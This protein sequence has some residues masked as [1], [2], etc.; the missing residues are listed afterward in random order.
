MP[1]NASK[2]PVFGRNV[3]IS[4]EN[5]LFFSMSILT[6]KPNRLL[7]EPVYSIFL[8]DYSLLVASRSPE[9]EKIAALRAEKRVLRLC[10]HLLREAKKICAFYVKNSRFGGPSGG[11]GQNPQNVFGRGGAM[12]PPLFQRLAT[13]MKVCCSE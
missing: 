8:I 10:Y 5:R 7:I 13:A 11:G 12:A 1:L 2:W 6:P 9:S 4:T 3:I